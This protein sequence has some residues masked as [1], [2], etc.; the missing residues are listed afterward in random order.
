MLFRMWKQQKRN[1][2]REKKIK[3]SKERNFFKFRYTWK[4]FPAVA[5]LEPSAFMSKAKILFFSIIL[6]FCLPF[7][8]FHTKIDPSALP[9]NST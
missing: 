1:K 7:I 6:L 8:A 4:S 9:V 3:K 5:Y 2:V